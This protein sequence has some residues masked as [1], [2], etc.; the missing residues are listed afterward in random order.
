MNKTE[1][2]NFGFGELGVSYRVFDFDN[3]QSNQAK[4]AR[5]YLQRSIDTIV[6]ANKWTF[7]R[8]RAPLQLLQTLEEERAFLYQLPSDCMDIREIAEEGHFAPSSLDI[9][10]QYRAYWEFYNSA[11]QIKTHVPS[12]HIL[13]TRRVMQDE[14]MPTHFGRAVSAQF[15]LD[16]GPAVILDK[17]TTIKSRLEATLERDIGRAISYDSGREPGDF[18]QVSSYELLLR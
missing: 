18:T 2:V 6:E 8:K 13:Y 11:Y 4:I 15:A 5:L 12:A 16:V 14:E 3:E 9:P 17:F 1:I 10:K 7:L